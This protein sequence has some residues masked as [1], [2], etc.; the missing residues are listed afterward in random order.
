MALPGRQS[1]SGPFL[2]NTLSH[3][4]VLGTRSPLESLTLPGNSWSFSPKVSALVLPLHLA[5]QPPHWV[6]RSGPGFLGHC[7]TADVS[8][9]L[10]L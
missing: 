4:D 7:S 2:G 10:G 3:R 8:T 9:P 5:D 6:H 1:S